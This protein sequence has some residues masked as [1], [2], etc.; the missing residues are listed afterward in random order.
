MSILLVLQTEYLFENVISFHTSLQHPRK[1]FY[2]VIQEVTVPLFLNIGILFRRSSLLSNMDR[3]HA[4]RIVSTQK[5]T[6]LQ[7]SN[8]IRKFSI[9]SAFYLIF[10]SLSAHKWISQKHAQRCGRKKKFNHVILCWI[11]IYTIFF[12]SVCATVIDFITN[13]ARR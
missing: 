4:P 7:T 11:Y 1:Q 2:A 3:P 6:L 5:N 12:F 13:A 8:K 10:Y 9:V